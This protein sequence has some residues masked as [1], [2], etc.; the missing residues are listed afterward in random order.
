MRRTKDAER[1]FTLVEL[2]VVIAIMVILAAFAVP[3]FLN[4]VERS[5]AAEAFNYLS[6]VAL[7]QERHHARNGVYAA[8]TAELDITLP[9]LEYFD[10]TGF[11]PADAETRK[12]AWSMTLTRKDDTPGFGPYTV[13]FDQDGF[14]AADSTIM[15]YP[16]IDPR[17]PRGSQ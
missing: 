13:V 7:A 1:G 6:R 17:Q 3:Q 9:A 15:Q 16:N 8:G 11:D 5:K 12:K 2:L 10:T 14:N 4:S